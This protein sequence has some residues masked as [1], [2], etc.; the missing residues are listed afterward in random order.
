MAPRRYRRCSLVWK[1][2]GWR[3]RKVRSTVKKGLEPREN[4][5]MALRSK[6][7]TAPRDVGSGG[8]MTLQKEPRD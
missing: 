1:L 2:G 8:W 5:R 3:E 7:T 6:G 4:G